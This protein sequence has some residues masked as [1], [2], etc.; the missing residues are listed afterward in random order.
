MSFF[1]PPWRFDP[2]QNPKDVHWGG[3]YC[4]IQLFASNVLGGSNVLGPNNHEVTV[5]LKNGAKMAHERNQNIEDFGIS[6]YEGIFLIDI[7][8]IPSA[9]KGAFATFK[10]NGSVY[11]EGDPTPPD[12]RCAYGVGRPGFFEVITTHEIISEGLPLD[13]Y[14]ESNWVAAYNAGLDNLTNWLRRINPAQPPLDHQQVEGL[15]VTFMRRV[16]ATNP[17]EWVR[18]KD[19]SGNTIPCGGAPPS[20]GPGSPTYLSMTCA[21]FLYPKG[22]HKVQA[23]DKYFP[24]RTTD[25]QAGIDLLDA[26]AVSSTV[27]DGEVTFA[28]SSEKA[29]RAED[30]KLPF[31]YP[32]TPFP[33]DPTPGITPVPYMITGFRRSAK[34][35]FEASQWGLNTGFAAITGPPSPGPS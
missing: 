7:P 13:L 22:G 31:V 30:T 9:D 24:I 35:S 34:D 28:I 10:L 25:N 26:Q 1:D 14:D 20:S 19:S 23:S 18:Q 12:I 15:D 33:T 5:T 4:L 11:G 32:S 3:Y 6:F 2:Y 8:G 21:W 27:S 16:G 17:N 29:F